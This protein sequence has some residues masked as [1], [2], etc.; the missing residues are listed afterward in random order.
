MTGGAKATAKITIT[1]A[2][3]SS[4]ISLPA[5]TRLTD[6]NS[7]VYI[8]DSD[9]TVPGASASIS[10]GNVSISNG[11]TTASITASAYGVAFNNSASTVHLSISSYNSKV[12]A[13]TNG[14]ISGGQDQTQ[15]PMVQQSDVDAISDQLKAKFDPTATQKTL[16][17]QLGD[18]VKMIDGSFVYNFG[19]ITPSVAVGQPVQAGTQVSASVVVNSSIAGVSDDDLN[20]W[21][22]AQAGNGVGSG[23]KVYKN[24]FD[25]VKFANF[26]NGAVNITAT[27]QIGLNLDANQI[28]ELSLGKKSAEIRSELTNK[29]SN[30]SDVKVDFSPFWISSISDAAR[31]KVNFQTSN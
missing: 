13:D 30:I 5:G 31:L 25:S 18:T 23:Q 26:A 16:T 27:A 19:A 21:L 9:T 4:S 10:G 15:L 29:Y 28:K 1:N 3:S 22:S 7:N 12:S 6:N 17:S 14:A 11:T 24:G 8:L 2:S 20:A